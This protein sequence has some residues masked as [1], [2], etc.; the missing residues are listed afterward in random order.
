MGN[1]LITLLKHFFFR[2]FVSLG[3][4][5]AKNR[6]FQYLST[7][8]KFLSERALFLKRTLT[9]KLNKIYGLR[10]YPKANCLLTLQEINDKR[11]VAMSMGKSKGRSTKSSVITVV[12]AE[13]GEIKEDVDLDPGLTGARFLNCRTSDHSIFVSNLQEELVYKVVDSE[14][15]LT[16][17]DRKLFK[18]CVVWY[19]VKLAVIC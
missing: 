11:D 14:V 3:H 17:G 15:D 10:Y 2:N 8:P 1:L 6:N 19:E 16:F 13:T 12:C 7:G 4:F 18:Q 9:K 5:R